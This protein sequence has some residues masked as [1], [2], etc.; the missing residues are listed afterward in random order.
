M[1]I[2]LNS[3]CILEIKSDLIKKAV[4]AFRNRHNNLMLKVSNA[5]VKKITNLLSTVKQEKIVADKRRL[6]GLTRDKDR[7]LT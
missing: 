1:K 7:F 6:V 4:T 2:V 3:K 5:K